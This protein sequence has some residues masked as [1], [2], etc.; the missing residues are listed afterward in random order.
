MTKGA[1]NRLNIGFGT[2]AP[3][4]VVVIATGWLL[5]CT[6]S[7]NSKSAVSAD[8]IASNEQTEEA[9]AEQS[10]EEEFLSAL[11]EPDDPDLYIIRPSDKIRIKVFDEE[12]LDGE[13]VVD[14]AGN[15]L[16]E[17]IETV[18]IGGLTLKAAKEH[19]LSRY[20][21]EYLFDPKITLSIVEKAKR[22]FVIL[23]QVR[24][25][26]YYEVPRSIKLDIFQAI[27][28]AGGYTRIAG[29]VTIKRTTSRGETSM[30]F[31]LSRLKKK[32]K[33]E[34]P[35]VAED[36]TVIVGESWF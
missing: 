12:E 17:L 30:K 16:L 11:K 24:N 3:L 19:V 6:A 25:P 23:G 22:R 2:L 13:H 1:N 32:P 31:R 29:K 36:D 21:A 4:L 10:E 8:A 18:K 34:V 33:S 14:S 15:V 26:G 7:R 9:A 5:G 35:L 20:E 28:M 27:A